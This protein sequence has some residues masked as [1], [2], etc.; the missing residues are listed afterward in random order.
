MGKKNDNP[1]WEERLVSVCT[2]NLMAAVSLN[3]RMKSIGNTCCGMQRI[4]FSVKSLAWIVLC[5]N[6]FRHESI[7]CI[8]LI[9]YS[10]FFFFSLFLSL[11]YSHHQGPSLLLPAHLRM[12]VG[13]WTLEM[14]G[15]RLAMLQIIIKCL[16]ETCQQGSRMKKCAMCFLVSAH[17]DKYIYIYIYIYIHIHTHI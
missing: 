13:E 1:H 8:M 14:Q 16:L 12:L 4:C 10:F 11:S 3:L 6:I 17:V 15:W 7:Y 2:S 9:Y 5:L